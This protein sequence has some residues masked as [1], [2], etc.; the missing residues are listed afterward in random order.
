MSRKHDFSLSQFSITCENIQTK[1]SNKLL[2]FL[3][4]LNFLGSLLHSYRHYSLNSLCFDITHFFRKISC[5]FVDRNLS[6][7]ISPGV[8]FCWLCDFFVLWLRWTNPG[9]VVLLSRTDLLSVAE[10]DVVALA[11]FSST[12]WHRGAIHWYPL[13]GKLHCDDRCTYLNLSIIFIAI[14]PF[15]LTEMR[16]LRT[17]L[18]DVK[19]ILGSNLIAD[20]KMTVAI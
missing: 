8:L 17:L 19:R 20:K 11:F 6:K 1:I 2:K 12:S 10:L 7:N 9:A 13:Q 18:Q 15:S 14:V 3:R 16:M 5:G 4:F